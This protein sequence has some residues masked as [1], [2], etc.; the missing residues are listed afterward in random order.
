[1][2]F[3]VFIVGRRKWHNL[4]EWVNKLK[5]EEFVCT[6]GTGHARPLTII[7]SMTCSLHGQINIFFISFCNSCYH[8]ST[9]WIY[10]LE[11]FTYII[12]FFFVF[13]LGLDNYPKNLEHKKLYISQNV[14]INIT[15]CWQWRLQPKK[16]K[17]KNS[18][19]TSNFLRK[20]KKLQRQQRCNFP[21]SRLI[22]KKKKKSRLAMKRKK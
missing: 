11:R 12:F 17:K 4:V 13:F 3:W 22:L 16:K 14:Y 15:V 2:D 21:L 20:K 10:R 18:A 6:Y 1:M 7:E 8:L 9:S 19:I 5:K